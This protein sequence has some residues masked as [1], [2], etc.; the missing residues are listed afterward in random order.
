MAATLVGCISSLNNHINMPRNSPLTIIE[1]KIILQKRGDGLTFRQIAKQTG[2]SRSV[3]GKFLKDP[4]G[5]KTI[6]RRPRRCKLS[7]SQ[8]KRIRT[9]L[10]R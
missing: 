6:R 10:G 1:Q 7:Y 4:L 3:I 8:R 5:Y 9:A 2:R